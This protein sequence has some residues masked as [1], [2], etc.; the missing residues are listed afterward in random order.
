MTTIGRSMGWLRGSLA[1]WEVFLLFVLVATFACGAQVSQ[2]FL[3]SSNI[4]IAL[5]GMTPAAIV[6]LPM[7]LI[8]VT[9]EIDISVG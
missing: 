3:R 1:R 4:S 5:A 8:I 2:Y 6:A 9:G 7:T